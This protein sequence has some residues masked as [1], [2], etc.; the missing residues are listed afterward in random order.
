MGKGQL[1]DAA[2]EA[3]RET[4]LR[5]LKRLRKIPVKYPSDSEGRVMDQDGDEG[6]AITEDD[7]K[8]PENNGQKKEAKKRSLRRDMYKIFDGSALMAIGQWCVSPYRVFLT[9]A[10]FQACCCRNTLPH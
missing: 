3:R 9:S 10:P 6:E 4:K 2:S 1:Y 5:R 8:G 7:E